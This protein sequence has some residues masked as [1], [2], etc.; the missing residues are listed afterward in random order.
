VSRFSHLLPTG[1]RALD[2]A[3]GYGRHA[4]FLAGLGL[5]V[6][7]VDRDVDALETL[8]GQRGIIPLKADLEQG[9]WPL[10]GF[11][12]DAV[13]VTSYLHRP[14]LPFVVASL[15]EGGVLLYETFMRGQEALGRPSRPEFLLEPGELRRA[16]AG[17][18]VVAF[19]EGPVEGPRPA[20]LQRICAVRSPAA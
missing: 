5:H 14:L 16:C 10:P 7:A 3:C 17:L 12:F 2:V 18:S 9:P 11:R 19:E 1:G 15:A 8:R 4:R 13:V 20:V 6:L